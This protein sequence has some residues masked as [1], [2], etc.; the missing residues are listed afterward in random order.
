MIDILENKEDI[1]ITDAAKNQYLGEM[2][3]L[4]GLYYSYL[5]RYYGQVPL[6]TTP[7][8]GF[9]DAELP[10]NTEAEVFAQLSCGLGVVVGHNNNFMLLKFFAQ[11]FSRLVNAVAAYSADYRAAGQLV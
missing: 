9:A 6:K 1:E 8:T 7:T 2:Y 11:R 3:F 10:L 5:V 4:R